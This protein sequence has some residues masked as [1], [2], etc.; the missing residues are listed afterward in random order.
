[1]FLFTLLALM[2]LWSQY[3]AWP[4]ILVDRLYIAE[5][6]GLIFQKQT[7]ER[8]FMSPQGVCLHVAK[9]RHCR[10]VNGCFHVIILYKKGHGTATL[11]TSHFASSF[12][13][14]FSLSRTITP[15][16]GSHKTSLLSIFFICP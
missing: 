13:V 1:M 6:F 14:G 3:F 9:E 5:C 16:I 2:G 10:S 4:N 7:L 15:Q 8:S 11:K 12:E